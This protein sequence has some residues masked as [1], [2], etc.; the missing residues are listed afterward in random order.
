MR[1]LQ[2]GE[3]VHFRCPG[4]TSQ[5]HLHTHVT[6]SQRCSSKR[7]Q[8]KGTSTLICIPTS[9]ESF[10]RTPTLG[11]LPTL[12]SFCHLQNIPLFYVNIC[13]CDWINKEIDLKLVRI[14][15]GGRARLREYREEERWGQSQ[16]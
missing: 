1:Y 14:E 6:F 9:S 5:S 7:K 11:S 8:R 10:L 16:T 12:A 3:L 13:D 2:K 15:L 4:A